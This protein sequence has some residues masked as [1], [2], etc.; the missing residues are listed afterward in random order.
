MKNLILFSTL[1]ITTLLAAQ[2]KQ[3]FQII[4]DSTIRNGKTEKLK[5]TIKGDGKFTGTG[6]AKN[7]T[8][9][10]IGDG[11]CDLS[12]I[13]ADYA[14]IRIIG[15]GTVIINTNKLKSKII[16]DGTVKTLGKPHVTKNVVFGD[17]RV[18]AIDY[19]IIS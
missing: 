8:V 2:T 18:V 13:K 11:I 4:G 19:D 12:N 14:N 10:V 1:F 3:N 7:I 5:V 9:R 16:G 17:G 15:D 6:E